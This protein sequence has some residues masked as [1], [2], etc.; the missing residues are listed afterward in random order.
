MI[1]GL[2]QVREPIANYLHPIGCFCFYFY[3]IFL[4]FSFYFSIG[5]RMVLLFRIIDGL[6]CYYF[7]MGDYLTNLVID[8][9]TMSTLPSS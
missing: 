7:E 6:N 1:L 3:L 8:K 5:F 2:S 4:Q 9:A